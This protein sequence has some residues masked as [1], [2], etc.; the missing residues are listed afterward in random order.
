MSVLAGLN[1][2]YIAKC[3]NYLMKIK[4]LIHTNPYLKDPA[5]RKE[6]IER[7]VRTSCGVEGIKPPKPG[8]VIPEIKKR[9][10]KKIYQLIKQADK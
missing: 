1:A 8:T 2:K 3:Y 5:K 9:K 10:P 4:S 7:S 6:L